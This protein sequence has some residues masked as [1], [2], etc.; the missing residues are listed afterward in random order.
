MK[1]DLDCMI[2]QDLLPNYIEKLTNDIT[3]KAIEEHII[4]CKQCSEMLDIMTPEISIKK[5]TPKKEL[6][7]L[8]KKK[9]YKDNCCSCLHAAADGEVVQVQL[10]CLCFILERTAKS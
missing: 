3:N 6:K 9:A 1:Q 7:F 8:K 2:V 5:T 4:S 10:N